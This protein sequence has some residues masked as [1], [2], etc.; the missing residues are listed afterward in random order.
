MHR[1]ELIKRLKEVGVIS[2]EPV[3]LRSGIQSDIYCDIKK[4]FG[5]SDVFT[6]LAREISKKISQNITCIAA[7][8][9]GGLPLAALVASQLNLKFSLVRHNAKDHGKNKLIDG[10]VPGGGDII[11]I[12][13]DVFSTGSSIKDTILSLK[14]TGAK[15]DCAVVVVKRGESSLQIPLLCVFELEEIS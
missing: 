10:Y 8:G 3:T 2:R 13:D 14:E 5:F 9:H 15:I 12:V 1:D 6:A 7:S 11:A 4:A